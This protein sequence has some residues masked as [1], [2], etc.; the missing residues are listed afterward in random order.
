MPLSM[1]PSA[2]GGFVNVVAAFEGKLSPLLDHFFPLAGRIVAN[3]LTWL[4]EV[5]CD[6]QGAELVV[7]EVGVALGSL[8][9]GDMD[10]SLARVGIPVQ[11]DAGAAL[12]VQ[13]VPFA[14]GWFIVAWTRST[15]HGLADGCTLCMIVDACSELTRARTIVATPN[16]D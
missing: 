10:A 1:G 15:N 7:V 11:Y 2:S 6:N 13:R 5:H 3:P 12:S 9:F 16:F 4:P 14:C 8:D